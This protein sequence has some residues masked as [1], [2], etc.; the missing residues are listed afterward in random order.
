MRLS[1]HLRS[2]RAQRGLNP[3]TSSLLADIPQSVLERI[4]A[5]EKFPGGEQ[6]AAL[7]STYVVDSPSMFLWACHDLVERVVETDSRESLHQDEDLYA[8]LDV[9]VAFLAERGRL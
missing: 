4:E 5:G 3:T 6:L 1:T 9:M 2:A 8:L 7:A